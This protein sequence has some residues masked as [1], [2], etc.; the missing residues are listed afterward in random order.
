METIRVLIADDHTLVRAGIKLLLQGL[1]GVDVVGE[2]GDGREALAL[3]ED[4]RP[5]VLLTDI[6]MPHTSGLELA[7]RVSEEHPATHVIILSMHA[8]E[9][10][11]TRALRAGVLGYIL[12]DSSLAELELAV[13]AVSQGE[14]YL[15]PA[16]SRHVIA[17]YLKRTRGVAAD[18]GPL[19]P[20]QNEVLRRIA[21]GQTTKAIAKT[22]GVSVKTVETHRLQLM[23]RLNIHDVAGLTRYAIRV[24]LVR[25]DS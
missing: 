21:E 20:R 1:K 4:L 14:I 23:E 10:Y 2:A 9:E 13:R 22:L 24:G 18:P 5:D 12:K 11:A 3:V 19:T 6:S 25:P 15:S 8:S 16:I 17:D 7:A